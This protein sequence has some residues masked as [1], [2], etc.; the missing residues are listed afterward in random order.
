MHWQ[1][2]SVLHP[3]EMACVSFQSSDQAPVAKDVMSTP[4]PA[5]VKTQIK[6]DTKK[7]SQGATKPATQS[8]KRRYAVG[9]Y[10]QEYPGYT[11]MSLQDWKD[12]AQGLLDQHAKDGGLL[13][14]D[15]KINK[16]AAL[17]VSEGQ[18]G[19]SLSFFFFDSCF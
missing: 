10:R 1:L 14:L 19:R 7:P 5:A 15:G 9:V 16:G 8:K 4:T 13:L 12:H 6:A 3:V 17:F 18:L 2:T 11:V